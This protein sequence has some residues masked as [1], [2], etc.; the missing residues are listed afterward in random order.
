MQIE[1][2]TSLILLVELVPTIYKASYYIILDMT[3]PHILENKRRVL[4]GTQSPY[5]VHNQQS[6]SVRV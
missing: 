1:S 3:H 2:S 6:N 5:Q 4:L